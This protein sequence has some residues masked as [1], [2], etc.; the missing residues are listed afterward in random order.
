MLIEV[1][2]NEIKNGVIEDLQTSLLNSPWHVSYL[3]PQIKKV[4]EEGSKSVLEIIVNSIGEEGVE[5]LKILI[6]KQL[7]AG[8]L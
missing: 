1:T 6:N 2:Q 5:K 7:A 4:G 3:A 8:N